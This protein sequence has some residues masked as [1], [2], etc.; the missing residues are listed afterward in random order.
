MLPE[1]AEQMLKDYK[2]CLGRCEYLKALIPGLKSEAEIW[3]KYLAVDL[4]RNTET[5]MDGM[6][7]G[8][9]VGNPTERL[10]IMLASGFTPSGL[11]ELEEEISRYEQELS[12]KTMVVH[13]VEAWLHG[14]TDKERWLVERQV[15]DG[16][17]WRQ[18]I[19]E[20][21]EKYGEEYSREGL[22]R[23]KTVAMGK[24][25]DMTS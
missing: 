12:E 21:K 18:I 1:R 25:Y 6:P 5:E 7:R 14:L 2:T 20:Y 11:K 3:H 15:I 19:V 16:A 10:G 22:K 9:N 24:I 17:Y 23:M 13:F 4:A 8:N